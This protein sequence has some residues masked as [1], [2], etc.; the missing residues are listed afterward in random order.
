MAEVKTHTLTVDQTMRLRALDC[1]IAC[2]R[3]SYR[4]GSEPDIAKVTADIIARADAFHAYVQDG[5]T[6]DDSAESQPG[7]QS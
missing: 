5:T 6:P 3:D 7:E 2:A 4:L 1:A